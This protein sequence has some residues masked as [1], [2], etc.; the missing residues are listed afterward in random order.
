MP[1][2]QVQ[3]FPQT[4]FMNLKMPQTSF[5]HENTNDQQN[6]LVQEILSVAQASQELINQDITWG[7][8][9]AHDDDFSFLPHNNNQIQDQASKSIEI[10][11]L[12]EQFKNERVVE[13]LRWVGMSNK[14]LEKVI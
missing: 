1:P 10:G 6:M 13:N 5:M 7:G 4:G 12:D 14:E 3:D 2:L 9:F 11:G 8:N